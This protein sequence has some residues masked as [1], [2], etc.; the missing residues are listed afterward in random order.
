MAHSAWHMAA[1]HMAPMYM[2]DDSYPHKSRM[3][4]PQQG[5]HKGLYGIVHAVLTTLWC[6][7]FVSHEIVQGLPYGHPSDVWSLGVCL[8]GEP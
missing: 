1:L 8:I 5:S 2:A 4:N 6:V 3:Y 7:Q